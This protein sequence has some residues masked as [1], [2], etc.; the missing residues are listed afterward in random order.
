M[1]TKQLLTVFL[2]MSILYSCNNQDN[3]ETSN[4][5]LKN[6]NTLHQTV[7]FNEIKPEHFQPAFM[8]LMEKGREEINAIANNKKA[9]TF[10]NTI[11]ALEN[12][13]MNI[14]RIS[15]I[16]FNL[17]N[18]ETNETIQTVAREMS[19][20]L[21]DYSNDIYL[22]EA[23]FERVKKV[24]E[25]VF[26]TKEVKNLT[27]EQ[28]KLLENYYKN[29]IRSG[30]LLDS[31]TKSRYREVTSQHA[32]ISIDFG[33]NVL[34]E[35]I[36]YKLHITNPENMAGIPAFACDA[37][38]EVARNE[39]LEGWVFTLHAPSYTAFMKYADN[40]KLREELFKAFSSKSNNNDELD[41]KE[42]IMKLT[43]LRLE[44]S[45]LLGYEMF[46]DYVLEERMALSTEKVN[47]FLD[48]LLEA[49]LPFAKAELNEIEEFAKSLGFK[50][51]I[52]RWDFSYYSE[53]LR[54]S[55]FNLTDEIIKPYFELE[56]VIN[57]VFGL[58]NKLWGLTY[59]LNP[60][61]QV[62]HPDVKAYEV[63]DENGSFLSVLYLDFHPR[64]SKR[65]GAWMTV[66]REQQIINKK[67]IRPQIS[68]VC[69]FTAP[70]DG[71]PALL[72]HSE[73][74]TFL[75]EFGHALHGMMSNVTYQSLAGTN[76]YRDF[77]E[78]PS[79][80]MEN[81]AVEKEWLQEVAI[82]YETLEPI[83]D[84]LIQKIIDAKNFQSGI[85]SVR[86]LSFGILDMAWHTITSEYTGNIE[87][88]ERNAMEKTEI[89]P[90]IDGICMSAAFNHIFA[91]GGVYATGYYSYKWAE[92]LDADAFDLFKQNGIFDK[93][94]AE[95][96]RNNIL[97]KG[98]TEHP[99]DLYVKFRGHEPDMMPLLKRNGLVSIN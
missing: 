51:K 34:D 68:L 77:V 21:S 95:N 67:N 86:Q 91:N 9:P 54:E 30:A 20:L 31:E 17:M 76:V 7:P 90:N 85:A 72:T 12:A 1:Q 22:N 52:Q 40:R 65:Q 29:F 25:Q 84:E 6:F 79:Q 43:A 15:S 64:S 13:G 92:V 69:N 81:W 5:L 83:S 89:F 2:L 47:T 70:V 18:A 63:F 8:I 53:K 99:M 60:N 45:Q 33:R 41:N 96:F 36:K 37:A 75:H 23:L 26:E 24:Y 19:P 55:K 74:G 87:S 44:M 93:K 35:N 10:E 42:N 61:I 80:I 66:Y 82:H 57:G 16:F 98:G 59:K 58:T 73:V 88:F 48:D 32:Q 56:R 97:S 3:M 4:P 28:K 49:S 71:N 11:V 38:A 78:L 46:S 50:D 14:E 94:T 62:Y 39:N 27:S